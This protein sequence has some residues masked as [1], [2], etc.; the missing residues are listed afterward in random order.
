[1]RT[2]RGLQ[3]NLAPA[4]CDLTQEK[5]PRRHGSDLTQ[6]QLPLPD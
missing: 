1:M 3:K 5:I 2:P 6:E 4:G